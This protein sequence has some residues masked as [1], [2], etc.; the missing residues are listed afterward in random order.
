MSIT[1]ALY[2]KHSSP[3]SHQQTVHTFSITNIHQTV[4]FSKTQNIHMKT[5]KS[6]S[7]NATL[8]NLSDRN[9]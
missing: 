8:L 5:A 9:C 2:S 4:V 1:A 3:L 7:E 6:T